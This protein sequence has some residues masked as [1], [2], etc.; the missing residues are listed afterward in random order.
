MHFTLPSPL[1]EPPPV[2]P[3]P[4]TLLAGCV[5]PG[6]IQYLACRDLFC[7]SSHR[8]ALLTN[9]HLLQ[10]LLT[11]WKVFAANLTKHHTRK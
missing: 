1:P 9:R 10:M 2:P 8:P 5:T 7:V 4:Q 6:V 3:C 11:H